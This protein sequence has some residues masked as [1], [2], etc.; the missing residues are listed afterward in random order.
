MGEAWPD[1]WFYGGHGI[2]FMLTSPCI[3]YEL[4]CMVTDAYSNHGVYLRALARCDVDM[5]ALA[6]D[7]DD[8]MGALALAE[9]DVMGSLALD[10]DDDFI[11]A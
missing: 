7:D 8:V 1:A 9:D 3:F 4:H 11:E 6:L 5:G 2:T 10:N